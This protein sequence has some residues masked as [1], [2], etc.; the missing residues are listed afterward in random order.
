MLIGASTNAILLLPLLL[1]SLGCFFLS[2]L[3]PLAI[4]KN[5]EDSWQPEQKPPPMRVA[6][7]DRRRRSVRRCRSIHTSFDDISII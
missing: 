6:G 5:E 1:D 2:V 3:I 4:G 7:G